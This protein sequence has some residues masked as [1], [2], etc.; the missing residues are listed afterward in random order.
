MNGGKRPAEEGGVSVKTNKVLGIVLGV[1]CVVVV[2]L[3]IG[4]VV[5][6]MGKS[7]VVNSEEDS[8]P[9]ENSALSDDAREIVVGFN[10]CS[11]ITQLFADNTKTFDEVVLDLRNQ[12]MN[13]DNAIYK[14]SFATCAANFAI[15]QENNDLA[16]DFLNSVS[17]QAEQV[18]PAVAI[19]YYATFERVYKM[20]GDN[21]TADNYAQKISGFTREEVV[22]NE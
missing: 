2:G 20:M 17:E 6:N 15:A 10:T 7:G 12:I 5:V 11:D 3:V 22:S 18:E 9:E 8:V 16:I 13:S 1:L 4:I 21:E 19:R 14:V